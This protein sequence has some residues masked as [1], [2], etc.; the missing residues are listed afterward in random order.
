MRPSSIQLH[1]QRCSESQSL[2]QRRPV[3]GKPQGDEQRIDRPVV[4]Q[5]FDGL[6]VGL[7]STGAEEYCQHEQRHEDRG[8][9]PADVQAEFERLARVE[10]RRR[11]VLPSLLVVQAFH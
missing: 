9:H 3:S 5:R 4:A 6:R 1:A 7:V 8:E 2:R 10:S 11:H